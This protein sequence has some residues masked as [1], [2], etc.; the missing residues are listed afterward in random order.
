MRKMAEREEGSVITCKLPLN[1]D[2]LRHI[3]LIHIV[4]DI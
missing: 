4:I 2:I 1:L 3:V